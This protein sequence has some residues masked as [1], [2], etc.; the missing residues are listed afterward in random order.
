[1]LNA[2]SFTRENDEQKNGRYMIGVNH[3]AKCMS[4]QVLRDFGKKG[5]A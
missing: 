5:T 1:M 3:I 4:G 2:L